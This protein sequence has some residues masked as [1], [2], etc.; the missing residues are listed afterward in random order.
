MIFPLYKRG[1]YQGLPFQFSNG[2][3][4]EQPRINIINENITWRG[5]SQGERFRRLISQPLV[6]TPLVYRGGVGDV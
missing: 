1:I 2:N 5:N 6:D 4:I 3:P